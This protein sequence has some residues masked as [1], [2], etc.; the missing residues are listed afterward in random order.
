MCPF[1]KIEKKGKSLHPNARHS[2]KR[3]KEPNSADDIC[4]FPPRYSYSMV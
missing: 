2:K 3:G 1:S 4:H